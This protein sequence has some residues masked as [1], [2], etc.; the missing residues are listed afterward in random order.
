[1]R[2]GT[3]RLTLEVLLLKHT[4][5]LIRHDCVF[6]KIYF[7]RVPNITRNFG[8]RREISEE[9]NLSNHYHNSK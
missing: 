7:S 4:P 6:L 3:I 9:K 2:P 5:L 8:M 1:M